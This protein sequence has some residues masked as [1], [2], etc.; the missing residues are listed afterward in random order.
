MG[1]VASRPVVGWGFGTFESA[2]PI[3]Q[4]ADIELLYDHAHNDWLEWTSE[5]GILALG[6][7]I[8]LLGV[9][10]LN[11]WRTT[12]ETGGAAAIPIACCA[13]IAAMAVHAAWDFSLRIPAVAV[14]GAVVMGMAL[15]RYSG[16]TAARVTANVFPASLTGRVSGDGA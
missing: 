6:V 15:T 7:A 10:L 12:R 2:F 4:S 8:T 1:L 3:V 9:A 13:A 11:T 14:I 16:E 5:G